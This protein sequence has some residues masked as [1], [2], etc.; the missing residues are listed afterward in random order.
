MTIQKKS[1]ALFMLL[2]AT[3]GAKTDCSPEKAIALRPG[4]HSG[5]GFSMGFGG[6]RSSAA[7]IDPSKDKKDQ[8]LALNHKLSD[9]GSTMDNFAYNSS[10]LKN[11]AAEIGPDGNM[12]NAVFPGSDNASVDYNFQRDLTRK[13]SSFAL[14]GSKGG[15][16]VVYGLNL[17]AAYNWRNLS[18]E[19]SL[20]GGIFPKGFSTV[21]MPIARIEQEKMNS[22]HAFKVNRIRPDGEA[23][24][25]PHTQ[26]FLSVKEPVKDDEALV[27]ANV[28]SE[29]GK[30]NVDSFAVVRTEDDDANDRRT[31]NLSNKSTTKR[32]DVNLSSFDRFRFGS[33]AT[34]GMHVGS[35]ATFHVGGGVELVGRRFQMNNMPSE[36]QGSVTVSASASHEAAPNGNQPQLGNEEVNFEA[37]DVLIRRTRRGADRIQ[38]INIESPT[39]ERNGDDEPKDVFLKGTQG[40]SIKHADDL[41]VGKWRLNK[42]HAHAALKAELR[43]HRGPMT[44]AVGAKMCLPRT[45]K[46]DVP[47][48]MKPQLDYAV[49]ILRAVEAGETLLATKPVGETDQL[50]KLNPNSGAKTYSTG[51]VTLSN[52]DTVPNE[53]IKYKTG[54][55]ALG[56]ISV[57]YNL[58]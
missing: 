51:K 52:L 50:R 14:G 5:I 47:A 10:L 21:S 39:Q 49:D 27:D 13:I 35:G 19:M 43:F 16:N 4:F 57:R 11:R 55:S 32:Y 33:F 15:L 42:A 20:E 17:H 24:A 58:S 41:Q 54:I 8:K 9:L 56:T 1:V 25:V 3:V 26:S 12:A 45:I 38:G 23:F 7:L 48:A 22:S 2:S 34:M 28:N 36:S 29:E 18:A 40:L 6:S 30:V 46:L 53:K 37:T 31:H 44:V